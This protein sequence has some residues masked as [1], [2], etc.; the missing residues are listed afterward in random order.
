MQAQFIAWPWYWVK[1][2][3]VPQ[4]HLTVSS[5]NPLQT[6]L[7]WKQPTHCRS[8]QPRSSLPLTTCNSLLFSLI[9]PWFLLSVIRLSTSSSSLC[10]LPQ[11]EEQNARKK[12]FAC[13]PTVRQTHTPTCADRPAAGSTRACGDKGI[14]E[15]EIKKKRWK[16]LKKILSWS[17]DSSEYP[18]ENEWQLARIHIYR[19]ETSNGLFLCTFKAPF[20]LFIAQVFNT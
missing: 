7:L 4:S 1:K 19:T 16:K 9:S 2:I 10:H 8:M 13:D 12:T 18:L 20:T 6:F 5:L 11:W 3:H 15:E 14:Q 17:G